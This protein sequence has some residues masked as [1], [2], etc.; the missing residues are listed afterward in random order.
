M[1]KR[2]DWFWVT[3][4]TLISKG[5]PCHYV[6]LWD[7]SETVGVTNPFSIW[8]IIYFG[9]LE[10]INGRRKWGQ[11][12]TSVGRKDRQFS[13]DYFCIP[14]WIRKWWLIMILDSLWKST[15]LSF[16]LVF[17]WINFLKIIKMKIKFP[18]SALT[19][20]PLIIFTLAYRH[21]LPGL[22]LLKN[23]EEFWQPLSTD[24]NYLNGHFCLK[25][26]ILVHFSWML[27]LSIRWHLLV[28]MNA[29]ISGKSNLT[30]SNI[31]HFKWPTL[32]SSMCTLAL[33]HWVGISASSQGPLPK[34][35]VS[36]K[37]QQWPVLPIHQQT[38]TSWSKW[39]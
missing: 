28:Q 19:L 33:G 16:K 38:V 23:M 3:K 6:C 5:I 37:G 27:L 39:L 30:S 34:C 1:N 29:R 31:Y 11:R 14:L 7:F 32:K 36:G 15:H 4:I 17:S 8:I 35:L 25:P 18:C 2:I 12:E 24:T 13:S 20:F 21:S 22:R 9:E 10:K 26:K